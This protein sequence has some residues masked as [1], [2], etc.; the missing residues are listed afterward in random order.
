PFARS[1]REE[2]ENNAFDGEDAWQAVARFGTSNSPQ[3]VP[4]AISID[5]AV[6]N[7]DE[8]RGIVEE[9][10]GLID[11]TRGEEDQKSFLYPEPVDA[12]RRRPH[13]QAMRGT[14]P[15]PT[16]PRSGKA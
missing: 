16:A 9:V 12:Q 1:F 11:L 4:D 5:D 2:G 3:D 14:R 15:D 8:D 6:V 7:A 10:D 13:R